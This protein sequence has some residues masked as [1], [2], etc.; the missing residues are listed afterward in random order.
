VAA[1]LGFGALSVLLMLPRAR[2]ISRLLSVLLPAVQTA[3]TLV[4]FHV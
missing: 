4:T 1:A 2:R 3:F